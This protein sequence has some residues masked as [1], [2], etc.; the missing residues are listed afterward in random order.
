MGIGIDLIVNRHLWTATAVFSSI[1][2]N[3]GIE[4]CE[5]GAAT[6]RL[7]AILSQ[8]T[9]V[10]AVTVPSEGCPGASYLSPE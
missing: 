8:L 9:L 1:A 6:Q 5:R 7:T 3:A 10:A 4:A 2:G